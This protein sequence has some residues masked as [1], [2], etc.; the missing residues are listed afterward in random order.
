M[1]QRQSISSR[2]LAISLVVTTI[3]Y[4]QASSAQ[5]ATSSLAV[6]MKPYRGP[7]AY[8]V[9]YVV[10]RTGQYVSTVHVAGNRAKYQADLSRWYR[11]MQRSGRGID[12]S[13]GA[14]VGS[15]RAFST[16]VRIPTKMLNAGY[17]L[18][19]ES[20]VEDGR[21]YPNEASIP[22]TTANLG[23]PVAGTG[24]VNRVIIRK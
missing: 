7:A 3:A 15:G 8:V 10:G 12:G 18:R 21:Y 9:A 20:A 23:K 4:P 13:T 19:V 11:L 5:A 24:Y 6:S 16:P 17:V 2:W 1:A 14:S 22:L